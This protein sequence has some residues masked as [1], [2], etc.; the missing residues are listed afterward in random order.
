MSIGM[1]FMSTDCNSRQIHF[2]LAVPFLVGL[3]AVLLP[4]I[5]TMGGE[6]APQLFQTYCFECHANGM[7]E[8]GL[9]LEELLKKE[10]FDATLLFEHLITKKMPPRDAEQPSKKERA[11]L[12]SA[13]AERQPEE[14]RNAFRRIS[15]FEFNQSVNDLLGIKMDLAETIA[16]D[17]GTNRFDT[18]RRIPLTAQ[19]LSA[20]FSATDQMLEFAFPEQGVLPE[21][22]WTT[23]RIKD[24]HHTYNIYTRPYKEGILF[25]WT[26]A[27]N[28][29]SYSY[30][31]DDFEPPVS[32][33]YELTFDAAK[34]GDFEEDVTIQVHAGKYY[35]ADDRPQPQRLLD[36]ISIGA[37]EVKPYTVRGF[38]HPGE[39]VSVHCFSK[40]TWRKEN[41]REGVYI[42]QLGVRGPLYDWP[43]E[44][45]R[46]IFNG[47]ALDL[48][49]R[50]SVEAGSGQSVLKTIGGSLSV[51]SFETGS[52]KERMMDGS[53]R[54]SWQSQS[55]GEPAKPPHFVVIE[56]P[57]NVQ[58]SGLNY[59]TS[60]GGDGN[61]QVKAYEILVSSN[62]KQW[63]EPIARGELLTRLAAEQA[64]RFAEPTNKRFIKFLITDSYSTDS[65]SVASIGK[66]D[67][68]AD[69]SERYQPV[70]V[71]V[72]LPSDEKLKDVIRRFAERAFCSTLN[73]KELAPFFNISL[74]AYRNTGEF[75]AAAKLGIKAILCSPRFLLMPGRH[76]ND[77]YRVAAELA[78]TL[79]LSVPDRRLLDMAKSNSLS[80][81]A[82]RDE[83]DRMLEDTKSERMVHSF[84]DQWLN[85]RTFKKVPPSLKLYPTY[86]DLLDYYLPRET[87]AYVRHLILNNLPVSNLIDSDFSFLNQRLAQHY[88]VEGVRGQHLRKVAFPPD[89]PRGGL[90]T[91]GSILKVTSD[92]F[93]TSP[94]LRGV[95]ISINIAGNTLATPTI[96]VT[97]I[98]PDTTGAKTIRDQMKMHMEDESCAACHRSIDPYGFALESFDAVGQL[99]S[100]YR[101][102]LPH[103]GTF[104]FRR[105]GYFSLAGEVDASGE[106]GEDTFEDVD[107]LKKILLANHKKIAYNFMKQLFE[108]A[109]G[110]KPTLPQRIELYNRI[111]DDAED[112]GMKDLIKEVLLFSF[113]RNNDD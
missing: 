67:V 77:S 36:V 83:I 35:F 20:Y 13:V 9:D 58:I 51:S 2:A 48:P 90:M 11:V 86:D 81:S 7:K 33:W 95:W 59:S 56:N 53:N 72:K 85:L 55:S 3:L 24:S 25:S 87:E 76:G 73:D 19:Q 15:R 30:F 71:P 66:L 99:R 69:V 100:R 22:T 40:H 111:P 74:D 101:I 61:G 47:L 103:E 27:N 26:R 98:E 39:S 110:Y 4:C 82:I 14:K 1:G 23:N 88:G 89:S 84:C 63:G 16:D 112:C 79:W 108:F 50:E 104:G 68:V 96:S 106:I 52:E 6:P 8:G 94:I 62:G 78:R 38:L 70:K 60:S 17:R 46:K 34:V 109:N 21:F 37:K 42:K 107:G 44:P 113:A 97:A 5:S 31:Y 102:R 54:T 92:G 75:V 64:I 28:G 80:E 91:M 29:N 32:G 41:T 49:A 12:L 43:P 45:F 93:D 18:D 105:E 65:T 10:A 57:R